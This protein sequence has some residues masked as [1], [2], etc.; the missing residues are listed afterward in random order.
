M[1]CTWNPYCFLLS[2]DKILTMTDITS[3]SK[4][5]DRQ[6][7]TMANHI[8]TSKQIQ[9]VY[10][11]SQHWVFWIYM[12]VFSTVK[13]PLKYDMYNER[14][15]RN[16]YIFTITYRGVATVRHFRHVPI[17]IFPPKML[18]WWQMTNNALHILII[19]VLC[20]LYW[21]QTS[22]SWKINICN[23]HCDLN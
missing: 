13:K 18:Y 20:L 15:T 22:T 16:M 3:S 5:K 9:Y 23:E 19:S 2:I 10:Y 14:W 1:P 4:F 11:T 7:I 21:W 17:H 8:F 6:A 12:F